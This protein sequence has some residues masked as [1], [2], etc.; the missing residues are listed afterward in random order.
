MY[1]FVERIL[2]LYSE[3]GLNNSFDINQAIECLN[4]NISKDALRSSIDL[5]EQNG[6][7]CTDKNFYRYITNSWHKKIKKEDYLFINRDDKKY[8]DKLK[9]YYRFN[10]ANLYYMVKDYN[11]KPKDDDI[12]PEIV[13]IFLEGE[14]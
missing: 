10:A 12:T 4:E 5:A 14:K 11:I 8:S 3:F 1:K 2:C 13:K 7:I 9:T 6:L